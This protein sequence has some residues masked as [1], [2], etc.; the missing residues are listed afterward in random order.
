MQN[1]RRMMTNA[2]NGRRREVKWNETQN[3]YTKENE[4]EE[5][6]KGLIFLNY[7]NGF[8][9][10][11]LFLQRKKHESPGFLGYPGKCYKILY[12]FSFSPMWF[13]FLG[14][15]HSLSSYCYL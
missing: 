11:F 5:R 2:S 14:S 7:V 15:I 4:N 10:M 6:Q 13:G 9:V 8:S 3:E 12:S 1:L